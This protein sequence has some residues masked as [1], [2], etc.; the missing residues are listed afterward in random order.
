MKK[1]KSQREPKWAQLS[2]LERAYKK[3]KAA[4][5]GYSALRFRHLESVKD[6]RDRNRYYQLL[7]HWCELKKKSDALR[8]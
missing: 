1:R 4:D 2:E 5:K 6:K 3:V 7:K 8:T